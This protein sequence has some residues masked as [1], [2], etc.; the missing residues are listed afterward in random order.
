MYSLRI[1]V[2]IVLPVIASLVVATLRKPQNLRQMVNWLWPAGFVHGIVLAIALVL[3]EWRDEH[4]A[5]DLA[6][7]LLSC[8]QT[9][10]ILALIY[11]AVGWLQF[12]I[13]FT[14]NRR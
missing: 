6:L 11:A 2:F 9:G 8:I 10:T 1:F 7:A 14:G 12:R 3:S 13:A 5:A 4:G